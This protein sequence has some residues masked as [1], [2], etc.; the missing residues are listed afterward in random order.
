MIMGENSK[1]ESTW[2]RIKA[3]RITLFVRM[4]E[5]VMRKRKKERK[6]SALP[7]ALSDEPAVS[8]GHIMSI[9]TKGKCHPL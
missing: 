6:R 8:N 9:I 1:S 4:E 7:F 5:E 2:W 3:G